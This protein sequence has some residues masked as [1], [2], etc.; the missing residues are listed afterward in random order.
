MEKKLFIASFYV[1]LGNFLSFNLI[2]WGSDF[3]LTLFR[4]FTGLCGFSTVVQFLSNNFPQK[5]S[6]KLRNQIF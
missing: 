2:F 4:I 5:L 3:F 6:N 1:L